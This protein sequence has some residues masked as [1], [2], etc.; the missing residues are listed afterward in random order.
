MRTNG[1]CN[2]QDADRDAVRSSCFGFPMHGQFLGFVLVMTTDDHVEGG[3][4]TCRYV[5]QGAA[6]PSMEHQSEAASPSV[7]WSHH[8]I[9]AALVLLVAALACRFL[10][11]GLV[12]VPCALMV[13]A[14]A[15]GALGTISFAFFC[16][17]CDAG[18]LVL[19]SACA[20][21]ARLRNTKAQAFAK[22]QLCCLLPHT[23]P[24]SPK[25]RKLVK[26]QM[27]RRDVMPVLL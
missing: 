10:V 25:L 24:K 17:W 15:D 23:A 1:A 12:L 16:C 4:I 18:L 11:F 13:T 7:Q 2:D 20:N 14:R 5:V 19:L 26:N 9:T 22:G 8:V 3:I 27:P 6:L 21:G